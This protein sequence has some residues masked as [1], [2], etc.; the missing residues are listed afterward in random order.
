MNLRKSDH[1]DRE[2][3]FEYAERLESGHVAFGSPL[4]A[5]VRDCALCSAELESMRRSLS[6]TKRASRTIEPT[7]ALEASTILGM[8]SQWVAHRRQVRRRVAKSAA[9]AA[10]FMLTMSVSLSSSKTPGDSGVSKNYPR[11]GQSA[12]KVSYES[13]ITESPEERLLE[14][15]IRESSWQPASRWEKSQSRALD[16]LDG[17]IDEALA[18]IQANPA[19]VRAGM[20]V[21]SN[22]EIKRQTLKSLYAQREL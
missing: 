20:V 6:V 4:A 10:V 3:L 11:T 12:S 9:I 7:I 8:K 2:G 14:P 18:A 22:R 1:P 17:D 19:L 21:N 5:H 15:A 13:L 16:V